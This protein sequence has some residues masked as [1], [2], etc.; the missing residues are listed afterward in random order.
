MTV[1]PRRRRRRTL[2]LTDQ[3]GV[4]TSPD[5]VIAERW[6]LREMLTGPEA[7]YFQVVEN[8]NDGVVV[9]QDG[10]YK[11]VNGAWARTTGYSVEELLKMSILDVVAPEYK[12][13][14]WERYKARLAGENPPPVYRAMI[15]RKD[16]TLR[17]IE[18]SASLIRYKGKPAD[19]AVIR[20]M[21]E[22]SRLQKAL[23]DQERLYSVLVEAMGHLGEG[24]GLFQDRN[25]QEAVC[26]YANDAF[27]RIMG[28]TRREIEGL[29][30]VEMVPPHWREIVLDTYRRLQKG[31]SV[32]M[33]YE[34]DVLRKDGRIIPV[35][36]T[37]GLVTHDSKPTTVVLARDITERRRTEQSLKHRIEMESLISKIS[38]RLVSTA[39][40]NSR[41][42][43][44]LADIGQATDADRAYLFLFRENRT[45]I[46]NT[47]EWCKEGVAPQIQNLQNVPCKPYRWWLEKMGGGE[48]IHVPD[49]SK[50]PRK[51]RAEK[52]LV[53]S[54]GI[55]SFVLVPV[56]IEGELAGMIGL[57]NVTEAVPWSPEDLT[58]LRIAGEMI[59]GVLGHERISTAVVESRVAAERRRIRSE[60]LEMLCRELSGPLTMIKGYTTMLLDQPQGSSAAELRARL[61]DIVRAADRMMG[62]ITALPNRAL[63][64]EKAPVK[65]SPSRRSSGTPQR[66]RSR[67]SQKQSS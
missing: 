38:S 67:R 25:D 22:S 34:I 37:M 2:G 51:A 52:A 8:A 54:Q 16:G 58:I 63:S 50:M 47:H 7:V 32:S 46:D 45:V 17:E 12:D 20:D 48:V 11:F 36:T 66:R 21:T 41:I 39:D 60:I 61:K 30:V 14:V 31:E 3:G 23:S 57:D 5:M 18:V 43:A 65:E 59:G 13:I 44:S 26:V 27:A 6:L 10:K 29:P 33:S 28:R 62:L 19:M 40:L 56:Y 53:E 4:E 24:I 35:E 55:K 42:T 9:I 64:P 15:R 49:V 1:A